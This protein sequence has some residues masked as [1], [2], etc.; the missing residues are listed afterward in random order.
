MTRRWRRDSG[1]DSWGRLGWSDWPRVYSP[2]IFC[3]SVDIEFRRRRPPFA[4]ETHLTADLRTQLQSTLGDAYRL[5]RELG[6]GGMSRVFEA[7]ELR[8]KRRVAVKVLA[9]ELAQGLSVSRF[10]REIQTAA[11][12][13]QANIVPVLSAGDIDGLPFYTMPFVD[14]ESLRA[15]LAR[16]SLSITEV[17]GVMRDVSKALAYAHRQGVVHRDIKPDNVL[18]SEG[19]AVV[20]DFGIAKAISA[21]RTSAPGATLTQ[22]GTSIGTP[23]YMAPEQAA[24]D[25]DIDHRADIYALGAMAYEL[26]AGR[27]V[28]A[29]RTPQRMLAAHMSE[30]PKPIA[31]LRP[32]TPALLA[33]LVM[34]CLAKDSND[35]PQAATEIARLLDTITS[36]S[37]MQAAPPV[38]FGGKGM[39]G[40]ALA[41]YAVAFVAVAILAKAAIVGIGLPD[42]VFPGS[43]ILMALGL[44][45]ILWTAYV[46]RVTRRA[47][48]AT[49]T[50]TPGG[51]PSAVH[52]TMATIAL[53]AAPHVSWY[54]TAKGGAYALGA[55]VLLVGA[56]MGLRATGIGPF[57]SLVAAGKLKTKE[58]LLITD[59]RVTNSDS[60]L[61]RVVSDAVRAGLAQSSVLSLMSTSSTAQALR[62]ME[63]PPLSRID[64]ALARQLAQRTGAKAIVDGDITGVG[65]GYIIVLRLVA[66]DSGTE[67]W[68]SRETGDGPRGLIDA[69]DRLTR[70]LRG[71]AGESLK[72][73]QAGAPLAEV[74][75]SSLDALRKYS[76]GARYHDVLSD[77]PNA[78]AKFREAVAIDSN[79]AAAWRKLGAALSNSNH[80][81]A[82]VDVALEQAHRHRDHLSADERDYEEAF[83]YGD[84]PGQDLAKSIA[85]YEGLA[86]RGDLTA[87]T[88][89][90]L[91]YLVR[92]Q[93]VAAESAYA[94]GVRRSGAQALPAYEITWAQGNQGHWAQAE[95]SFTAAV[96][97]YPD[98]SIRAVVGTYLLYHR[99]RLDSLE[100]YL[101]SLR[102][103]A[104]ADVR[105]QATAWAANLALL[106][107]RLK[108]AF[109]LWGDAQAASVALGGT[110]NALADSASVTRLEIATLGESPR[111]LQR[112]DGLLARI[113]LKSLYVADRPYFSVATTYARLGRPDRA[114]AILAEYDRDVRDTAFRHAHLPE[115]H[116]ARGEIELAMNRP[117]DAISEFQL[118]DQLDGRP[119]TA[120]AVCLSINLARAYDM[121]RQPDSAIVMFER[122]LATP[123]FE[124]FDV[125]LFGEFPDP[126]DPV[127]L[128]AVHRRLA[129][130]YEAKGDTAKAV[131]QYRAFIDLWK[132]ADPEVQPRVVEAR[133][134]LTQLT[135]V[136][137]TGKR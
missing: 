124:R 115:L 63:K 14:G 131:E 134:R 53:K 90:G 27:P 51:T 76:E 12:L 94:L 105:P 4:R 31:E 8:L 37:G 99:Q 106:R 70:T 40:K 112:M 71:K 21:A 34:R 9:P 123:Y 33:D 85:L 117:T 42:W 74:T 130:L 62:L 127:F 133:R 92:R 25:P 10:E 103:H 39:F 45:V 22:I 65:G 11:A 118:G 35:R 56:F 113:P 59:F 19:T 126:V 114:L 84:G 132:N 77:W 38:L 55:F 60:S 5:E 46:Q 41:I 79:F 80:P 3:A 136:E 96:L 120:C 61:G 107:G 125:P 89:L 68:S 50:F 75:T 82:E 91:K 24:G 17:I 52:G 104:R 86:Q 36:G 116:R 69:T 6:G 93:N 1:L 101:D 97:R 48:T 122:Y 54:R 18:L 72:A 78:I 109:A 64:L 95:S 49:P 20:T 28:F 26:L 108:Q 30:T 110:P 57:G 98:N 100:R 87:P 2:G 88:N 32:D 128:P 135:P 47:Y 137:K 58:P 7:E 129:E 23:A 83:Y 67:L 73:V 66:A 121:A 102:Q 44:P 43:L 13:Q 15:R 16:G 81:R 119:A 29:D 111:G